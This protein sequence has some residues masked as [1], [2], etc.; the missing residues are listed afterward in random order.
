MTTKDSEHT[1]V[2]REQEFHDPVTGVFFKFVILPGTSAPSRIWFRSAHGSWREY[3]FDESGELT[4][5]TTKA[6]N[7]PPQ[8]PGRLRLVK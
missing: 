8:L 4:G 6:N 2:I 1:L 5:A 7:Q 3:C